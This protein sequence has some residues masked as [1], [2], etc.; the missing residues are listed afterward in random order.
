VILDLWHEEQGF[1]A[2]AVGREIR[3]LGDRGDAAQ[4]A[5]VAA[6]NEGAG[7]PVSYLDAIKP[8]F[9]GKEPDGRV[10]CENDDRWVREFDG[11][12]QAEWYHYNEIGHR[13]IARLLEP[14]DAFGASGSVTG[15][16]SVD[17]VFVVDTTGSM[18]SAISTVKTIVRDLIAQVDSRTLSARYALVDYRD[19]PER[20]GAQDYPAKVRTGFTSDVDT[21]Q[22]AI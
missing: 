18:G 11:F 4:R 7:A 14:N 20:G 21:I 3:A 9:A 10:C 5:A 6:S 13:E 15:T 16:G 8:A 19:F 22:S 12:V 2:V 1:A 17:I